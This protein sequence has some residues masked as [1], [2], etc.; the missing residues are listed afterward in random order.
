MKIKN[1]KISL[2]LLAVITYANTISAQ[3]KTD[4]SINGRYVILNNLDNFFEF[5]N[6]NA[7]CNLTVYNI[8]ETES[9]KPIHIKVNDLKNVVKF[10]IK[11]SSEAYENQRQ[12]TLIVKK[13]KYMSTFY[14]ALLKMEIEFVKF[15]GKLL[16]VD[17]FYS[18]VK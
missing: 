15:N 18:L 14:N 1:L 3:E 10:S 6:E 4:E 5:D 13:D 16:E 11:S 9:S 17:K 7:T 8:L 2:I 12:A